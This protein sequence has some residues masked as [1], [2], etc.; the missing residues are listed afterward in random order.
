MHLV[1]SAMNVRTGEPFYSTKTVPEQA[2]HLHSPPNASLTKILL[3]TTVK[4]HYVRVN[5]SNSC[6]K[7]THKIKRHRD[8][9]HI[10]KPLFWFDVL[11]FE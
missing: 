8:Y 1:Y 10:I 2:D 6:K 7:S 5:S 4:I 11:I 3:R 9:K